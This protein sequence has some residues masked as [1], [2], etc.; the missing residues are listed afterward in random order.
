MLAELG[1]FESRVHAG[2]A[3][4]GLVL[5]DDAFLGGLVDLLLCNA[6]GVG[7]AVEVVCGEFDFEV[8]DGGAH[9]AEAPAVAGASGDVLADAFL[10]GLGVCHV[11]GA[12]RA[13]AEAL[14]GAI[15]G[16]RTR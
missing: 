11:R 14:V 12:F 6:E 15:L 2:L 8:L 13:W 5:V 10:G 9:D 16:P 1:L 7:G 4:G 3:A